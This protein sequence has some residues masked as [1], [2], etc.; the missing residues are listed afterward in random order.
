MTTT[1]KTSEQPKIE[2]GGPATLSRNIISTV[3][4]QR[5]KR[6]NKE[7]L[8]TLELAL[9]RDLGSLAILEWNLKFLMLALESSLKTRSDSS[10]EEV[11]LGFSRG[12]KRTHR[13]RFRG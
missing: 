9:M 12:L 4:Y 2:T 10:T 11:H 13:E 6:E 7:D 3:L 1:S 5:S 8:S